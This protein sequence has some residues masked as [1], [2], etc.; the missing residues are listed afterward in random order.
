MKTGSLAGGQCY[1]GDREAWQTILG[2]RHTLV[3]EAVALG[4]LLNE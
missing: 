3:T 1:V 4:H 2:H